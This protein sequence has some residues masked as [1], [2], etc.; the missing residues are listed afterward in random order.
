[1]RF[2]LRLEPQLMIIGQSAGVAAVQ[3]LRNGK[4][5]MGVMR[6]LHVHVL[7]L[8]RLQAVQDVDIGTLQ[9]RLRELG[10]LIDLPE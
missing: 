4:Q 1:M 7:L 3:A 9:Q 8:T 5:V 2:S 6:M 10:Q